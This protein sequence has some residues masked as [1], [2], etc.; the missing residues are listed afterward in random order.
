MSSH[1][2]YEVA[3]EHEHLV[4]EQ[5]RLEKTFNEKFKLGFV[6]H[7]RKRSLSFLYN[8]KDRKSKPIPFIQDQN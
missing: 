5:D 4:S 3:Q 6:Q 8:K 1:K 7:K 2:V